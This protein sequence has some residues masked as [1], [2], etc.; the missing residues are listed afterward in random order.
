[1]SDIGKII[2][3]KYS[4][5][6]Y[7]SLPD[8][9]INITKKFIMD[10]I[11]T[12]LAGTCAPGCKEAVELFTKFGGSPESTVIGF[13][14][15]LPSPTA[16]FINSMTIHAL[17]FDDTYDP[18]AMHC[19][20]SVLS[21]ALA[22]AESR[23]NVSGKELIN[24]VALGV[25]LCARLGVAINS[26]LSWIRTATCGSFASAL[27]ASKII[28][29]E[30]GKILNA[31]GIVYSQTSGNAQCLIDGGLAKR[32]QPAF[33]ARA[34][35]LS[36]LMA[37]IGLTGAKDVFEGKFGFFN[38]YER[39]NYDRS[40]IL[41]NLGKE[42]FG[43]KISIKPY[44]SCRMTHASIDAALYLK[45]NYQFEVN[46]IEKVEL[47]TSKMV[48]DMVGNPFEIRENPQVDAQFSIPYTVS[49]T[50]CKGKPFINDFYDYNVRSSENRFLA[51][52]INVITDNELD[53][54]DIKSASIKLYLNSG[55]IIR[56]K[57]NVFRG[58]PDNPLS[59]IE[60]IEKFKKCANFG[61]KKF[62]QEELEQLV[63]KL[64]NLEKNK[65]ISEIAYLLR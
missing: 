14:R 60:Y 8:N 18:A 22:L 62:G 38:L 10:S 50:L 57:I 35:V 17:D 27:A 4:K 11:G 20:T 29:L 36:A 16:A 30:K 13:D 65:D 24:A 7:C 37:E 64:L 48:K 26:P 56:H 1:V 28:K 54:R 53:Q 15:K 12:G 63:Y 41:K 6:D 25:D 59:D 19:Y 51:D 40:K 3:N 52:K 31:L 2:S 23:G 42:F 39:G 55:N 46:D 44:P 45:K 33:A 9:V 61:L 32:M 21:T 58:N 34:G 49:V 5:I 43:T 47:Y